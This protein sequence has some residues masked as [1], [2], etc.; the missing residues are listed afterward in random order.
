[1][2]GGTNR[3]FDQYL[4]RHDW[5]P[6]WLDRWVSIVERRVAQAEAAGA[7]LQ[8]LIV[9]E[10]VAVFPEHVGRPMVPVGPRPVEQLMAATPHAIHYPRDALRAQPDSFL[11][12]DAHLSLEGT[13]ILHR[14][15]LALLG[16]EHDPRD[17]LEIAPRFIYGELGL[18]LRP[19]VGEIVDDVVNGRA[20]WE[21][22]APRPGEKPN[23]ERQVAHH[24]GA[25]RAERVMVFGDS[26]AFA[27][28]QG[29]PRLATTLA[30]TFAEVQ[31]AWA[32]FGWDS[33]LVAEL[34]PDIVIVECAE[35]Y[36]SKVPPGDTDVRAAHGGGIDERRA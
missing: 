17:G 35:R 15:V 11:R 2:A 14:E 23:R 30:E 26:H 28:S 12:T 16:I 32:P 20:T 24:P 25:P 1:V 6:D 5:A 18:H 10:K 29:L 36:L 21:H 22:H 3:A 34:A 8:L 9:P 31:Y 7:R 33:E 19:Q 4:G 27:G 13:L